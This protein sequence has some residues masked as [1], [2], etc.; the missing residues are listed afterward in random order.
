MSSPYLTFVLGSRND[1]Y[2]ETMLLRLQTTL[3]V[4]VAQLEEHCLD[5]EIIIVE[6]NPPQDRPPLAEA[7]HLPESTAHVTIRIVTVNPLLHRKYRHWERKPIHVGVVYNVGIRRARGRFIAH[8]ASDVF[9][10]RQLVKFLAQKSLSEDHVYRCDRY[11]VDGDFLADREDSAATILDDMDSHIVRHHARLEVPQYFEIRDLHT[12]ACGDFILMAKH[13]WHVIRGR[14]ESRS[15]LTAD[16]DSLV[17]HAACAAGA[18]E[19]ELP[20]D[21]RVYKLAH[22]SLFVLNVEQ[23]WNPILKA[24]DEFLMRTTSTRTQ[25][26][27]RGI[28]NY[29]KRKMRGREGILLDSFERNFLS[30]A[31]KWARGEGPYYLNSHD[32]G[33]AGVALPEYQVC[34]AQW[35]DASDLGGVRNDGAIAN[36]GPQQ[37]FEREESTQR[38]GT[39]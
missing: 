36:R 1:D 17:L 7:L 27:V 34:R 22:K 13:W 38:E 2:A 15:V 20:P 29:P 10:S 18:S 16:L 5:T 26:R 8:R 25:N 33:L 24:L 19:V 6:W 12:N 31:Q 9:Y 32:W 28:L 21:C 3:E 14:Y 4:F 23:H 35:D 37:V 11:D 39:D 30:K